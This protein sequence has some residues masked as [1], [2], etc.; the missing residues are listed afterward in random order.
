MSAKPVAASDARREAIVEAAVSVFVRYGLARTTMGDIAQ[1]AKISRPALYL[2][3]SRKDDVFA[4]AV[5]H[6][7]DAKLDEL[8]RV[9]PGLRTLRSRLLR[10]CGDWGGD[11]VDLLR[12]HP[13]AADLFD[14][15]FAA[16][17]A[18][19]DDFIALVTSVL[20]DGFG[21][22]ISHARAEELAW[23]LAYS[24]RGFL[25]FSDDGDAM[26][27]M[28]ALEVNLILT[29]LEPTRSTVSSCRPS[30]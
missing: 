26:R 14:L 10:I 9:L 2:V 20:I 23:L 6:M 1:A 24:M 11:R 29:S 12:A 22:T 4:A 3:F 7:G 5:K 19:Y 18:M 8:R 28:I 16:V 30:R 25:A 21:A 17:R 27:R 15:S 13:D